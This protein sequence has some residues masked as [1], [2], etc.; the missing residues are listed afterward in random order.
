M[1]RYIEGNPLKVKRMITGLLIVQRPL[2]DRAGE[3]P[4][5]IELVGHVG[6][7]VLDGFPWALLG[8][9]AGC[10]ATYSLLLSRFPLIDPNSALPV[11]ALCSLPF[12]AL[13]V[14]GIA[15]G[16]SSDDSGQPWPLVPLLS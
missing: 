8:Y 3:A 13:P 10:Q 6:L 16:S 9:S 2:N 14:S 12:Q 15:D 5:K 1:T 7:A 4:I 11:L